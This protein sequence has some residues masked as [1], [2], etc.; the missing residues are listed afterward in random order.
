MITI[1]AERCTG[2]G[3]CVEVCPTGALY[4]VDCKAA[5][6]GSL[7]NECEACLA[8]CP[9]TAMALVTQAEEVEEAV[10]LPAL[11]QEPEIVRVKTWPGAISLRARVLP[12][13]GAAV[14][15]AGRELLPVLADSLLNALDRWA[16]EPQ[17][18][19]VVRGR[20]ARASG[21]GGRGRRHRHHGGQD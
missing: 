8:V 10:S 19:E 12:A 16:T 21:S 3:A 18:T 11:R 13:V 7:C 15:W 6:D 4:L 17:S 20:E 14:V 1:D 2:C 9:T 5:V